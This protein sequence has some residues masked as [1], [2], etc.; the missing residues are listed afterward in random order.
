MEKDRELP[1]IEFNGHRWLVDV[2]EYRIVN[3]KY[4]YHSIYAYDMNYSD[5]GY[6]FTIWT[7]NN[8][9]ADRSHPEDEK[10]I[11]R[12]P[13]FTEM[14]TEGVAKKYGLPIE[15]VK[16][17]ADYE[18]M[19]DK[20]AQIDRVQGRL[21]TMDLAG[22]T[23][24][25]DFPMRML[26]PKDNFASPGVPFAQ[27]DHFFN[28]DTYQ[29]EVAYNKRYQRYEEI[30]FEQI[31]DYPKDVVVVA[32]PPLWELDP[33]GYARNS[34]FEASVF[35]EDSPQQAHFVAKIIPPEKSWMKNLINE[36][37]KNQGLPKLPPKKGK[38]LKK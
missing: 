8:S 2:E 32:F 35:L 37:R 14:D 16:G 17:K 4:D 30:D 13:H 29:Y 36:N 20:R 23:F 12:L 34:K 25:V 33:I 10:M 24:Y 26:R 22:H 15:E 21:T 27:L 28:E 3:K 7:K 19:V 1:E 11:V 9:I 5:E 38:G 31:I 6:S 18:I